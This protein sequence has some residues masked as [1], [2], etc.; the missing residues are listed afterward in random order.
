MRRRLARSRW[1]SSLVALPAFLTPLIAADAT[2]G[3]PSGP[4]AELAAE[5]WEQP[6]DIAKRDLY[7]GPGGPSLAPENGATFRVVG[8]DRKGHSDGYDVVDQEGRK[9]AVKVGDEASADVAVSRILWAIGYQQPI[10]YYVSEWKMSDGKEGTPEPGRFRLSS[11][12]KVIGEWSWGD[13]PFEGTRPFH[14]LIVANLVVNNWDLAKSQNRIYR[15]KASGQ[16]TARRYVVQDVGGSLGKTRWPVGTRNS[17]EEFESEDLI[18]GVHDGQVDFT[19]KARHRFLVKGIPVSDVVW[20][21]RLLD[22]L[23]EAQLDDAFR[24][25]GYP[26]DIRTRYVR[27]IRA[28]I[29][30]GIALEA[31]QGEAR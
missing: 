17:I 18:K 7:F 25:A 23:S 4:S 26:P 8:V 12:H 24:A 21:C 16:G 11:D 15:M 3:K 6:S 9:W 30:E 1:T 28:K 27:K 14:G 19:Y 20:T 31:R 5:L 13:N 2:P 10:T 29:Q 22:R